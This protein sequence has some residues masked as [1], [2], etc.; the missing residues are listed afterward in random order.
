MG[1]MADK[2]GYAICFF[3]D[4]IQYMKEEEIAALVNAIHR[5]NQLRLP[6]MIFGAGLPKILKDAWKSEIIFGKTFPF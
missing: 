1:K 2:T 3:V 6:L 5:C 4:E